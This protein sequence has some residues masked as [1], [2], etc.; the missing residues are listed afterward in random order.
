[1]NLKRLV[2]WDP[3]ISPHK[4]QFLSAL[5]ELLT[6]VEVILLADSDLPEARRDQGWVS[7]SPV[8][9][10]Q[11]VAPTVSLCIAIAEEAPESTL[12]VFSGLRHVQTIVLGLKLV[13]RC[14][15]KYALMSEP[16]VFEGKKGYLRYFQSLV[17][18]SGIR[19]E[20]Q[21]VLAIG[22]NGPPW[23]H[24]VGYSPDKVFPFA[25][26]VDPGQSSSLALRTVGPIRV[27]YLG[28]LVPM[29]GVH[30]LLEAARNLPSDKFELVIAGSGE[31]EYELRYE[32]ASQSLAVE[33]RGSIPMQEVSTFLASI[34]ILV[35]PSISSDDG[36]GVVVS[37]ALLA[38][39]AVIASSCV[40]A[41]VV[42]NDLARGVCVRPK[43]AEAIANAINKL[44]DNKCFDQHFRL[45]RKVWAINHLSAIAGAQYFSRLLDHKFRGA[46]RPVDFFEEDN[47]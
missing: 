4:S 14:G 26:F 31:N 28:R 11:F 22:R 25:Y 46:K 24:S 17:S 43:S 1:M 6:N 3:C 34:D 37:E 36:W 18:E 32:A 8:G 39:T 47:P 20:V 9:Y 5:A 12:H 41:S 13:R 21:F 38:G 7:Y 40:G 33:F 35:L 45:Y 29:K 27:G 42:L 10:R 19:K 15:A 44:V 30:F 16:R 2:F 23:F